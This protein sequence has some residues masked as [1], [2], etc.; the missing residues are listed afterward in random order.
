MITEHTVKVREV[1]PHFLISQSINQSITASICL[2][3]LTTPNIRFE[4]T[5]I[6]LGKK[7]YYKN[8]IKCFMYVFYNQAVF[9]FLVKY[10]I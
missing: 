5:S 10:F 1:C 6:F 7:K 9:L 8:I 4:S 3:L 2:F